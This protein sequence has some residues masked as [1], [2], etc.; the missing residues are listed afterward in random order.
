[1]VDVYYREN[2]RTDFIELLI[3]L[4]GFGLTIAQRLANKKT[5]LAYNSC[6][7]DFSGKIPPFDL[8]SILFTIEGSR[9]TAE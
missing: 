2:E 6:C 1:M 3:R 9:A 4:P 8:C 5:N 7:M